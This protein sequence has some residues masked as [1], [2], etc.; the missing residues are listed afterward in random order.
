MG[1]RSRNDRV[2]SILFGP[3][4]VIVAIM[5]LWSNEFRFDFH[6]AARKTR[7][8]TSLSDATENL[9]FSYTGAMDRSLVIPGDYV[10]AFTGYLVVY[11][12]AEIYAW[13]RSTDSDGYEEWTMRW[14]S[15]VESNSRNRGVRQQLSSKTI[16]PKKHNVGDLEIETNYIEFVD[17]TQNISPAG[18]TLTNRNLSRS[19]GYLYLRKNRNRN[20]GDER[21]SYS[22]IPIPS[23]ATYFGKYVAGMGVA[24][25]SQKR[26]GFISNL[27]QDSGILHHIVAGERRTALAT[28]R[29][30]LGRLKWA[31]RLFGTLA[32]IIGLRVFFARIFNF[33][34]HIPIIGSLVHSGLWA[35]ALIIGLPLALGTILIS[36]VIAHPIIAFV[37]VCL[38]ISLYFILAQR[39]ELKQTIFKNGL[40]NRFG[41]RLDKYDLK[42]LEFIELAKLA[43]SDSVLSSQEEEFLRDWANKHNWSTE[44]F[45][46]MLKEAQEYQSQN[47]SG[48]SDEHLENLIHI[49]LADGTVTPF[50]LDSIRGV[51]RRS[52]YDEESIQ[53]IIQEVL[54][55]ASLA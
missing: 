41:A 40:D 21:V 31:V 51:A 35:L 32:I 43:F 15:R 23:T 39:A 20:L 37:L 8:L 12:N 42:E 18:L 34:L 14:M 22:G 1:I 3:I 16:I 6:Q 7:E 25:T 44:K 26:T 24:D 55:V 52:G 27:I 50:E 33:L 53:R 46:K 38:A 10:E 5:S 9:L 4:L 29:S 11:R 2:S 19:G 54:R 13:R 48:S 45:D 28:M 30:Y 36:Y 49:A 17:S 47:N